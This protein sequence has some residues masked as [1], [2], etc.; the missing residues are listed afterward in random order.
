MPGRT[1]GAGS[2]I[3]GPQRMESI[4]VFILSEHA[5][6]E[7]V[8]R[9]ISLGDLERVMEA[10]ERVIE[11]RLGRVLVQARLDPGIGGKMY[12]LRVFVDVDRFPPEVVTVYRTSKIA[13]YE[14]RRP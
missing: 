14:R 3:P 4:P 1:V 12:L 5:A 6:R 11:V 9:G 2:R 7:R 10:P 13:K 8:R